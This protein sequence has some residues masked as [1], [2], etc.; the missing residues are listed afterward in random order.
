VSTVCPPRP[1][2]VGPG[3]KPGRSG[4]PGNGNAGTYG[5]FALKRAIRTP[6]SRTIDK[7]TTVGRNLVAWSTNLA[8]DL[9]GV[10]QLSNQQ[11]TLAD[12][13]VK[14]KLIL[15]AVDA[16]VLQQPHLVDR[17]KKALLPV[18]RERLALVAQLQSLLRNLGLERRARDPLDLNAYLQAKAP[19]GTRAGSPQPR[20]TNT[21]QFVIATT[22]APTDGANRSYA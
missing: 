12:E 6:G 5:A 20:A 21:S 2:P 15:G 10:D 17:K 22:P 4:P 19:P 11:R 8:N 7:H 1:D 3:G 9:G 16:W 13:A 18:V 14:L